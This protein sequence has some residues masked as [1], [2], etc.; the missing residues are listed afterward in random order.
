MSASSISVS[1]STSVSVIAS[2]L[3][4]LQPVAAVVAAEAILGPRCE[5][6]C[7]M[8]SGEQR[9]FV[10]H[11]RLCEFFCGRKN[12]NDFTSNWLQSQLSTFP[13]YSDKKMDTRATCG[14]AV[15]K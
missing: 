12:E 1:M 5:S 7:S 3:A 11:T 13:P 14:E 6:S 8:A 15:I 2:V 10:D 9:I 4:E